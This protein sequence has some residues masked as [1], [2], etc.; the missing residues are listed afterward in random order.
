[1]YGEGS[2]GMSF[3]SGVLVNTQ[4]YDATFFFLFLAIDV[5]SSS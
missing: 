3:S 5:E 4:I 1:M 2:Y